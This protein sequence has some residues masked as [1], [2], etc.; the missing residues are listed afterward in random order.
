MLSFK[1]Q[2]AELVALAQLY[3]F[4]EYPTGGFLNA[5]R[6]TYQYF[7][8]YAISQKKISSPQIENSPPSIDPS[9]HKNQPVKNSIQLGVGISQH[10][11]TYVKTSPEPGEKLRVEEEEH[12]KPQLEKTPPQELLSQQIEP[13]KKNLKKRPDKFIPEAIKNTPELDYAE[14][15]QIFME[16]FPHIPVLDEI[17][18]GSNNLPPKLSDIVQVI[19]LTYHE[20][21]NTRTFIQN[22]ANAITTHLGPVQILDA[23]Q[24]EKANGWEDLIKKNGLRLIISSYAGMQSF[25]GLMKH[26]KEAK[27]GCHLIGKTPICL[28]SDINIY[29]KEPHLKRPLW[30]SIQSLY[31]H[32]K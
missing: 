5:E 3:F 18:S 4:Q 16:K 12:I 8:E 17:P 23:E 9:I 24:T 11:N 26:F 29:L 13:V 10:R 7:K 28:L 6:E 25:P 30:Q 1:E 21:D 15:R 19:I 27:N 32:G 2:Y 14:L 22:L 20:N 31:H